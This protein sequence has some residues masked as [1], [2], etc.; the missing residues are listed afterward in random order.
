MQRTR[1]RNIYHKQF[2][3]ANKVAYNQQRNKC[4]TILK[5]SKR[6]YF[7]SL[8]VKFVM[9]FVK[10]SKR[11]WKKMSPHFLNKIK[12]KE[13]I[14]LSEND[15]IISSDIEVAKTYLSVLMTM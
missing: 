10:D 8:L 2:T 3:E 6:S 4:V 5:K 1:L 13:W 12:S 7:E 9:K 15:E 11:F 14:T